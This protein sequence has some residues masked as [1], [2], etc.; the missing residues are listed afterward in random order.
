ME[1]VNMILESLLIIMVVLAMRRNYKKT[2]VVTELTQ[3]VIDLK[4]NLVQD[5]ADIKAQNLAVAKRIVV[6]E[7]KAD[8]IHKVTSGITSN[9]L[10]HHDVQATHNAVKF[11]QS[12][13]TRR[14]KPIYDIDEVTYCMNERAEYIMR[15][16]PDRAVRASE[17]PKKV[18]A[19]KIYHE[20]HKA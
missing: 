18:I 15:N 19:D 5:V 10:R 8:D 3:L 6:L 12:Y 13:M 2:K 4:S 7:D 16:Y 11:I 17:P 9:M 14:K 20:D 1:T